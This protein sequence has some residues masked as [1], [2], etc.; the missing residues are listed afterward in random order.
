ML[1]NIEIQLAPLTEEQNN[2]RI[3]RLAKKILHVV[4]SNSRRKRQRE[5]N[6]FQQINLESELAI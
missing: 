1:N 5:N 2:E 6:D 4:E 3:K